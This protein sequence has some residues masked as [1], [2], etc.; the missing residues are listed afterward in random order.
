MSIADSANNGHFNG[1]IFSCYLNDCLTFAAQMNPQ[2][3][4]ADTDGIVMVP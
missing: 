4:D 3:A 2:N 1:S